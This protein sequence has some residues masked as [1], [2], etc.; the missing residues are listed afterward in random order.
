[1]VVC[2]ILATGCISTPPATAEPDNSSYYELMGFDVDV[3]NREPRSDLSGKYADFLYSYKLALSGDFESAITNMQALL[4]KDPDS[5][6]LKNELGALYLQKGD[7]EQAL[8]VLNEAAQ[9]NPV[10]PETL[11]LLGPA[12]HGLNRL[13]E[14]IKVYERLIAMPEGKANPEVF[15][16]LSKL[17]L[18]SGSAAEAKQHI[19]E[20]TKSF[21]DNFGFSFILAEIYM[22]TKEYGLAEEAYKK[23]LR[24]EPYFFEARFA[25]A[26]LYRTTKRINDE[27]NAYSD[28]L[29]Y[30]PENVPAMLGITLAYRDAKRFSAAHD[31]MGTL[32]VRSTSDSFVISDIYGIYIDKGKY[33]DALYLLDGILAV[34]PG[35]MDLR[36]M[37]A[38][39][40]QNQG[41]LEGAVKH[42]ALI[43]K[44]SRY[45]VNA[46]LQR[47][48]LLNE[49]GRN[50]E[51][52]K[53]LQQA[54]HDMPDNDELYYIAGLFAFEEKQYD[55]AVDYLEKAV[56]NNPKNIQYLLQLGMFLEKEGKQGE[57][58]ECMRRVLEQEPES[59]PALNYI[60]YTYAD[61][62][63]NL[64][65]AEKLILKAMEISPGDGYIVDSL[66]WVYYKKGQYGLALEYLTKALE[67]QDTDP[68][69][70]EH[71]GD[72]HIK[73]NQAEKAA[74]FYKEALKLDEAKE[75]YEIVMNKLKAIEPNFEPNG[76]PQ[77][78]DKAAENSI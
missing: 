10:D 46:A 54:M 11:F 20:G 68:V 18:D 4:Q 76:Q 25:L 33:V 9:H 44:E 17:Y 62:G 29:S 64:D 40:E 23:T 50:A 39:C 53:V 27:I 31:V 67:M 1:M 57:A 77:P 28:I 15:F 7:Y 61:Q 36:Y 13:P 38:I 74:E 35:N 63:R 30:D 34:A 51:S 42:Y 70:Y 65:E 8:A 21:P 66:G 26:N 14:A 75:R 55:K 47:V 2:T 45:Y 60:G 78:G 58:I 48:L 49:L 56:N 16:I 6:Y 41:N 69:I 3:I 37:A 5:V 22:Q 19:L 52:E 12:Y 24:L 59:A 71:L 72:V 73:L 32:A 43:D